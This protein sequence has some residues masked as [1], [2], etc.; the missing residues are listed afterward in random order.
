MGINPI[1]G[2]VQFEFVRF[3]DDRGVFQRIWEKNSSEAMGM[4]EAVQV[5]ISLNPNTHTLRGLHMLHRDKQETK[6]VF[7]V[8]GEIQ[9]VLIDMRR[10]SDDFMKHMSV[11]LEAGM[12]IMVP[13]G[14]AH[15]FLTLAPDS[16]VAYVMGCEFQPEWEMGLHWAD[17]KLAIGW[18]HS[19][20]KISKKDA[21][22]PF[23]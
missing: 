9:D 5:S 23:L 10:E 12:G 22:H 4:S 19:P 2:V 1:D 16:T 21:S 3:V 18:L 6:A 17:P 13:P 15:G 14:V 8:S 7:C 11:R 20:A